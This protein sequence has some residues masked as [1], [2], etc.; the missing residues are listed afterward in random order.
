MRARYEAGDDTE[1]ILYV[2]LPTRKEAMS[3]ATLEALASG[4]P[5]VAMNL[6]G[7][8]DVVEHGRE[9]FLAADE[10][11]FVDYI[12]RLIREPELRQQMAARTR[13]RLGRFAWEQVIA[14]HQNLF[15]LA[16]QR[17]SGAPEWRLN[18]LGERCESEAA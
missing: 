18:R 13:D 2:C 5:A 1:T 3:I 12:V 15:S 8:S 7:V 17:Q 14:R 10:D 4:C 11:Q 16:Q 9:G 6:G